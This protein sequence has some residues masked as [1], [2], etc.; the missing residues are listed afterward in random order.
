MIT[1]EAD[2]GWFVEYLLHREIHDQAPQMQRP[3]S[4]VAAPYSEK[5]ILCL[6]DQKKKIILGSL[7]KLLKIFLQCSLLYLPTFTNISFHPEAV[8]FW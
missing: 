1:L 6:L 8:F 2:L 7:K 3:L 4:Q 5:K